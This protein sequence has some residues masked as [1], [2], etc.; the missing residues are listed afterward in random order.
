MWLISAFQRWPLSWSYVASINLSAFVLMALDKSRAQ[1]HGLRVPEAILFVAALLGGSI[2][3]LFAMRLVRHKTASPQ[4]QLVL[5]V[6]F[7]GQ[8]WLISTYGDSWR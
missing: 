1:V 5:G 8:L 6:I 2:G 3:T 4:F 7:L